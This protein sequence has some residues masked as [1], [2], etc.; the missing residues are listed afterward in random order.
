MNKARL[1]LNKHYTV[2]GWMLLGA[3]VIGTL[4]GLDITAVILYIRMYSS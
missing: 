4:T 2:D 1:F 3:Y